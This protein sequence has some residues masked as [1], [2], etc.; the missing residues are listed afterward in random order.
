MHGQVFCGKM[1]WSFLMEGVAMLN[2]RAAGNWLLAVSCVFLLVAC[3]DTQTA[4]SKPAGKPLEI[5]SVAGIGPINAQTPFNLHELTTAFQGFNVD[6]R[7]NYS[8]GEKYPVIRVSKDLKPLL[9][10]NPD[11]KH[12]KIYSVMV[13]D[14]RIGNGLGHSIGVKFVDIYAYGQTEA[15][16]AG[17]EELSGKVLCYA[18]Q[19]GNILY[20]FGGAWNGPSGSVPPKDVLADWQLEAIIWKPLA[21]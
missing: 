9:T 1:G 16:A 10:I 2:L 4:T 15:C 19:T 6:Q 5:L 3:D 7:L 11:V 21:K 17:A 18:P 14:N 20:L 8:E 12:E 13:H